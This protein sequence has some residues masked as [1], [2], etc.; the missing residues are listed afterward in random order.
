MRHASAAVAL[1]LAVLA[2]QAP[3]A[4]DATVVRCGAQTL[5]ARAPGRPRPFVPRAPR[6]PRCR[7][8]SVHVTGTCARPCCPAGRARSPAEALPARPQRSFY[9]KST[10]CTGDKLKE[11]AAGANDDRDK[12]QASLAKARA[13]IPCTR[14]GGAATVRRTGAM[15]TRAHNAIHARRAQTD[16]FTSKPQLALR[17]YQTHGTS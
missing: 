16:A 11:N 13:P 8:P 5:A 2:L 17:A 3:P 7:P 1:L 6:P 4:V 9:Y 14:T 12:C 15:A 10:D